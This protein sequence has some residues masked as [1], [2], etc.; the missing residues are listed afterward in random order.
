MLKL[1]FIRI[2]RDNGLVIEISN[3]VKFQDKLSNIDIS[4]AID[5]YIVESTFLSEDRKKYIYECEPVG[6]DYQIIFKNF[7][8]F[9]RYIK[10]SEN[11]KIP[12]DKRLIIPYSHMLITGMTGSGKTTALYYLLLY[13]ELKMGKTSVFVID[14]KEEALSVFG[15]MRGYNIAVENT[16]I[17]PLLRRFI[18]MMD[19]RKEAMRKAVKKSRK[20][21][22]DALDF[23][24]KPRVMFIDELAALNAIFTKDEKNEF[25]SLLSRV[26]LLG[27]SLGFYVIIA[28]Q[29]NN[30][31][32]LSTALKEQIGFKV[33]LGNSGKQSYATL[34]DDLEGASGLIKQRKK[35]G[36]GLYF[37]SFD[38]QMN[39][40][41]LRFPHLKFLE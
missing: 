7:S 39:V 26:I 32:E 21:D 17:L 25:Y 11:G 36:E 3:S 34:F 30:A 13:F 16:E 37:S 27:R 19:K 40:K 18:L 23:G 20:F 28:L 14:P 9:K 6:V 10:D 41:K 22:S 12:I 35:I 29:Q 2:V 33:V 24:F 8:E 5:G 31:K 15:K 4:S 1:P 38:G